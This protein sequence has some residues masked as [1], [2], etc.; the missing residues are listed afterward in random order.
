LLDWLAAQP[1][2]PKFYWMHRDGSEEVAALG[3]VC[4]FDAAAQASA[5]VAAQAAPFRIWGGAAFDAAE[6]RGH[7][8]LGG[9]FFLPRFELRQDADGAELVINLLSTRSLAEDAQLARAQLDQV[10]AAT[11]VAMPDVQV[12]GA[13]HQPDKA[14][15]CRLVQESLAAIAAGQFDKVVL[16]RKTTLTLDGP[17]SPAQLLGAS[18]QLNHRCFHFMLAHDAGHGCVG[19]SPERAWQVD[20]TVCAAEELSLRKVPAHLR[21]RIAAHRASNDA[22]CLAWLHATAAVAGVPREV[23]RVHKA[24]AVLARLV[25]RLGR[26]HFA[27]PRRVHRRHPLRRGAAEQGSFVRRRRPRARLRSRGRVA[28]DRPQGRRPAHPAGARPCRRVRLTAA[29]PDW[30]WRR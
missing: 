1:V 11:T 30:R 21:R 14:Q 17:L 6:L 28:G 25:C 19:S 5:F 2:F 24:R 22:E 26:L 12:V 15:W 23:A 18:R 13:Q 8:G 29:G 3:E 27:R 20:L 10:V 7:E 16:G 4:R 9:W